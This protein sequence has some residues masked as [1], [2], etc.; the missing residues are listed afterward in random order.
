VND[1]ANL[2]RTHLSMLVHSGQSETMP[3]TR[4][5]CATHATHGGWTNGDEG[6]RR[7]CGGLS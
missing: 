1:L 2:S 4:V 3:I 6:L 5:T 7:A